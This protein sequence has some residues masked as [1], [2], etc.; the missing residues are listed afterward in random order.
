[1]PGGRPSN[2]DKIV[3]YRDVEG[4][5]F[6]VTAFERIVA[7]LRIGT[8]LEPASAAAGCD[9]HTVY[10]WL[11]TG[12]RCIAKAAAAGLDLDDQTLGLTTHERRCVE[13]STAVLEADA[14][15][16]VQANTTLDR[17]ARGGLRTTKTT[18]KQERREVIDVD[19]PNGPPA[20]EYVEIERTVTTE[21]LAPNASVLMWRL[22]R[23]FPNRYI[24][25]PHD[26][27]DPFSVE[28]AAQDLA[29]EL[30]AYLA[31]VD[32]AAPKKRRRGK[33]KPK[34]IARASE[35]EIADL[36]ALL[37]AAAPVQDSGPSV[38]VPVVVPEAPQSVAGP[39]APEPVQNPGQ[40]RPRPMIVP[41]ARQGRRRR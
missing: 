35:P 27:D 17:L 38:A 41:G 31:G 28:E 36:E 34:A 16:D 21:E 25:T 22:T 1:M 15:W 23:R 8:F 18:V 12:A 19:N 29:E 10:G 7:A 26:L 40:G 20:I 30:R 6:P 11:R 2:I 5:P 3:G 13:F 9:K 37:P 14:S 39:V 33:T 32:D 4:E 24:A